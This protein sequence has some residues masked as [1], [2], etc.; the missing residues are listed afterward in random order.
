M[1]DIQF[2]DGGIIGS[3]AWTPK[4]T[5]LYLSGERANEIAACF[6]KGPLETKLIGNEIGK[7]SALKMCLQQ[8]KGTSA[9]LSAVLGTAEALGIR[10]ELY[11]QWDRVRVF[12]NK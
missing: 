2:V 8:T 7:A 9:L 1:N 11:Q 5:W 12:Q 10:E 6:S 4:E 3:P